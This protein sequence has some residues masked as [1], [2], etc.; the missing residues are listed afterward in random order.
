M[1]DADALTLTV[2]VSSAI[3]VTV[4]VTVPFAEP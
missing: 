1:E 4:I 3:W 2:G